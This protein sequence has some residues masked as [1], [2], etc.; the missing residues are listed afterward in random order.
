MTSDFLSDFLKGFIVALGVSGAM[1][2]F[3]ELTR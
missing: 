1:F 3:R 2:L